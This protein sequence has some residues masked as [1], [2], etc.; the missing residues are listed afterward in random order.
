MAEQYTEALQERM[1]EMVSVLWSEVKGIP[2]MERTCTI[3]DLLAKSVA[4]LDMPISKRLAVLELVIEGLRLAT[5]NFTVK[6]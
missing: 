3:A 1:N 2:E 6:R 5:Y 4:E